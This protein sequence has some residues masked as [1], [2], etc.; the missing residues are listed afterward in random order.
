MFK[1][2]PVHAAPTVNPLLLDGGP[3]RQ[4]H[5]KELEGQ[6]SLVPRV[7]RLELW[8]KNLHTL[9]N[10]FPLRALVPSVNEEKGCQL[11]G[12]W[13]PIFPEIWRLTA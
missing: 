8:M 9:A 4:A 11:D 12:L 10:D 13:A 7:R 6:I 5:E 2:F 1:N 3:L